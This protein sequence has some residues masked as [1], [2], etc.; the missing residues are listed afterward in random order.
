MAGIS[1]TETAKLTS[2][3][4]VVPFTFIQLESFLERVALSLDAKMAMVVVLVSSQNLVCSID[5]R[6]AP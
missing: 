1:H 5:Y 2:K 4:V 3:Q 6:I